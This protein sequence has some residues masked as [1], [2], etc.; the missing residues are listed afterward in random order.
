MEKHSKRVNSI[1]EEIITGKKWMRNIS[2]RFFFRKNALLKKVLKKSKKRKKV[3]D[4]HKDKCYY[5][6]AD[7]EAAAGTLIIKQ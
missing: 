4:K 5:N 6:Q 1:I 7:C 2:S 3:V